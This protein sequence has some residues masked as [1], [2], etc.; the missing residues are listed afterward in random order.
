LYHIAPFFSYGRSKSPAPNTPEYARKSYASNKQQNVGDLSTLIKNH[1]VYIIVMERRV[2]MVLGAFYLTL[3]KLL[4]VVVVPFG[5]CFLFVNLRDLMVCFFIH[6]SIVIFVFK[7]N[8]FN[9]GVVVHKF[10]Y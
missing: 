6:S 4:L 8:K 1:P 7:F 5:C 10:Y 2:L 3:F 9:N